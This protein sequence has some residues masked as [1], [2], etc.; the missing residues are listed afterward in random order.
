VVQERA[1][2]ANARRQLINAQNDYTTGKARLN[3]AMG[4]ESGLDFEVVSD[5]MPEVAG[6]A[7]PLEDLLQEAEAN[8]PELARLN[9]QVRAQ[10]LSLKAQQNAGS[11]SLTGSAGL[12]DSGLLLGRPGTSWQAGISLSWPLFSGGAI[13][14]GISEAEA[15][16]DGIRAQ[17]ATL[18]QQVRFELTEAK[19]AIASQKATIRA[20]QE[21]VSNAAERL[22]LAEGRYAAGVGNIIELADA[23]LALTT[24]RS[25]VVQEEVRLA[26]ARAQ[27][28]KALGRD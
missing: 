20:A 1:N 13:R 3:Q 5:W 23:Q 9:Q 15:N 19:L 11:P 17:V 7:Q 18:R 24:A 25:Q 16:L 4:V 27:L 14:A 8:R 6:E 2:V 28:L 12:G 26:V 21:S 10:E 22:K